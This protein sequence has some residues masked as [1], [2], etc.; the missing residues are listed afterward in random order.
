[1]SLAKKLGELFLTGCLALASFS[2]GGCSNIYLPSD[3][4]L[5]RQLEMDRTYQ[6]YRQNFRFVDWNDLYLDDLPARRLMLPRD[7][8]RMVSDYCR[9]RNPT[10]F[11][12]LVGEEIEKLGL[13]EA[14]RNA[15]P[16]QLI[17]Y[18][19]DI[20]CDRM[21]GAD[22]D[23]PEGEFAKKF[24]VGLA[25]DKYFELGKG[26]CDK[27]A[28]LMIP[29]FDILKRKNNDARNQNVYLSTKVGKRDS[30]PAGHMWNQ[31][32]ALF[33]EKILCAEIDPICYDSKKSMNSFYTVNMRKPADVQVADF[34][35]NCRDNRTA[36]ALY[37]NLIC[38][39][40]EKEYCEKKLKIIEALDSG[41]KMPGTS[42]Y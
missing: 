33:P 13:E 19:A 11:E 6:V 21:E 15:E 39:E 10:K 29:I 5:A 8:G 7:L 40:I 18:A 35:F 24:G 2:G 37:Q 12:A 9:I 1:M 22:V 28:A 16:K 31:V 14:V 4:N 38:K 41:L 27:F 26:D 32:V 23:N 36:R 42:A 34:Y 30:E 3:K 17:T 25:H 20:L